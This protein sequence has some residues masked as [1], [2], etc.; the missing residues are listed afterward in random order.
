MQQMSD[1]KL[2]RR[3]REG[4][5]AAFEALY[6]RYAP[7]VLGFLRNMVGGPGSNGQTTAVAEDLAQQT[8]FRVVDR[9]ETYRPQNQFQAWL[10]RLAHRIWVDDY[11]RQ[12]SRSSVALEEAHSVPAQDQGP[13]ER[14]IT[15]ETKNRINSAIETLP[16]PIRETL[17]LRVDGQLTCR[18]IAEALECPLGTVLWRLRDARQRLTK[19]L[20][21]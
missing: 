18:E 9:I 15:E 2:I 20:D 3:Y 14:Q 6:A 11:R 4:E 1:D 13:V 17:L 16:D 7:R 21:P 19:I 5:I 10:F 12:Q 8:W